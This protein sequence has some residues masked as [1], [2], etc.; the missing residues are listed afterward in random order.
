MLTISQN[1]QLNLLI[2]EY[3]RGIKSAEVG[4]TDWGESSIPI[5]DCHIAFMSW[6]KLVDN[7]AKKLVERYMNVRQSAPIRRTTLII[8]GIDKN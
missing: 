8:D 4:G 1:V 6:N 5:R 7:F 2:L 3:C